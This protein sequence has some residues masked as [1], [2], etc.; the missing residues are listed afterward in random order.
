[1]CTVQSK[2]FQ[3]VLGAVA[4]VYHRAMTTNMLFPYRHTTVSER[5]S[6]RQFPA[7]GLELYLFGVLT[8]FARI[9]VKSFNNKFFYLF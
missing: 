1:M 5:L 8:R 4:R 9:F 6:L 7:E 2:L 3:V